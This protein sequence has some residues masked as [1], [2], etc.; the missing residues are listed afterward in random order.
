MLARLRRNRRRRTQLGIRREHPRKADQMQA[1]PALAQACEGNEINRPEPMHSLNDSSNIATFNQTFV[2]L[3]TNW[4][5]DMAPF[6]K[7]VFQCRIHY[8]FI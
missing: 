5:G 2:H 3:T 6:E 1:R 4:F 7:R 8:L